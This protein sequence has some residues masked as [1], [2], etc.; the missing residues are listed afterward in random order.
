MNAPHWLLILNGKSAGR[1]DVRAAVKAMRGRGVRLDVRVTW[2]HGDAE[3]MVD[4]AVAAGV[5]TVVAGGG[6]GTLGVV[7]GAMARRAEDA[8]ALPALG[9]LPL[10]TANDFARGAGIPDP[11]LDALELVRTTPAVGFDLLRVDGGNDVRWAANLA[12]GGF[13]TRVT[14]ETDERLKQHLGGFAYLL[15]G[16]SR[17][18]RIE[19]VVARFAGDGFAWEGGFLALGI[20]NGRQAGGGQQLCPDA[21]VDDGLLDVTLVPAMEG[22]I[23]P[24]LRTLVAEGR[25]AIERALVCTRLPWLQIESATPMLLNLDGEPMESTRFRIDAVARRLR[26][27]LPAGCALLS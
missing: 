20:G 5:D 16:L 26:M 23:G 7:A 3:R 9:L 10:G 14:L 6:D 18:D 22:E 1:A 12:T 8:D 2:E 21:L 24:A 27:H 15:T 11:P 25:A 19:P 4:D 17:L 13:G